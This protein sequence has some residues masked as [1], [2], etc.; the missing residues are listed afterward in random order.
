MIWKGTQVG[1]GVAWG[2]GDWD[3]VVVLGVSCVG[4]VPG[5]SDLVEVAISCDHEIFWAG[6]S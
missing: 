3:A 1:D 4:L 6:W 2:T 5:L